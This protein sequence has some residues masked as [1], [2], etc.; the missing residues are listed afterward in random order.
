MNLLDISL[1]AETLKE[2]NIQE[3]LKLFKLEVKKTGLEVLTLLDISGT[4]KELLSG[5]N[6]IIVRACLEYPSK[7][8]K[9]EVEDYSKAAEL[10]I[11]DILEELLASENKVFSTKS[12]VTKFN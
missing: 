11:R 4:Q 9:T 8:I 1:M 7:M 6:C 10:K 3:M 5:N 2:N 12:V